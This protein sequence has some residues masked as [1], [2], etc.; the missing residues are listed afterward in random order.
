MKKIPIFLVFALLLFLSNAKAAIIDFT[1]GTVYSN[2]GVISTTD[3]SAVYYNVDKYIESGFV[4]DFIEAS[5]T[6]QFSDDFTSIIGD[7]YEGAVPND[8]IHG[9]WA[10]GSYGDLLEIRIYREDSELFDLNYF[11]LTSNTDKGGA[12]ASGNEMAYIRAF[13]SLNNQIGSEVLLP[14]DDWGW[15]GMN[16]QVYLGSAF[17]AVSYV[18][19]TPSNKIDCFGMDMFYIDEE[20]PPPHGAVPEP[21]GL[22]LMGTGILCLAAGTKIR[23]KIK[24]N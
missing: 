23:K 6:G 1:G 17:D 13:D 24:N 15:S 11:E 7:Y 21:G 10:T 5:S 19:I 12:A 2:N 14:P 20:A 22:L 16:P 9:H 8:V 4:L 3:L 18:S